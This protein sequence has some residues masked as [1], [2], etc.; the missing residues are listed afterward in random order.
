[1]HSAAGQLLQFESPGRA[2]FEGQ[3]CSLFLPRVLQFYPDIKA[4]NP[5]V[6]N[7]H[8][9][10]LILLFVGLAMATPIDDVVLVS[11]QEKSTLIKR[12]VSGLTYDH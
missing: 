7:M 12:R 6:V 11:E 10:K 2:S 4:L 1:M 8:A 9:L 3:D 5:L